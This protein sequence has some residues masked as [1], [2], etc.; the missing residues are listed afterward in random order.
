MQ[1]QDGHNILLVGPPGSGKTLMAKCLPSILPDLNLK[2]ALEITKIHSIAGLIC[3]N[4]PLITQRPFRAPHHTI[5]GASL[6]RTVEEF[7]NRGEI[8][9]AHNGVLF[10]DELTEFRKPILELLRAP[11]EERKCKHNKG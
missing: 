2:E 8:S 1:Q 7:Q 3:Q 4:M 9:L 5:S 6:V 11:L 10:L